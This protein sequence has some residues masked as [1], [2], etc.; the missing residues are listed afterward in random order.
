MVNQDYTKEINL[1]SGEKI[2]PL[3]VALL[4]IV[5]LVVAGWLGIGELL[6]LPSHRQPEPVSGPPPATA[7]ASKP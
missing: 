6:K 5:L 7:P 1:D 3:S 2:V 4:L